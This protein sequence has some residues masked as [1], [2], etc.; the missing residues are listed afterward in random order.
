MITDIKSIKIELWD[1]LH[2][3]EFSKTLCILYLSMQT[4]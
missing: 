4:L 1:L 3:Y 2:S